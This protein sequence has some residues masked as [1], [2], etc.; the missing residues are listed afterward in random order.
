MQ[1][2]TYKEKIILVFSSQYKSEQFYEAAYM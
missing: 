1:I 2:D